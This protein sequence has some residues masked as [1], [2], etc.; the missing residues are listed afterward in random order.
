MCAFYQA[1]ALQVIDGHGG[2]HCPKHLQGVGEGAACE[3]QSLVGDDVAQDPEPADPLQEEGISHSSSI[4]AG[5]QV[6]R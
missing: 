1:I 2:Y 3:L 5:Q 4:D 6:R